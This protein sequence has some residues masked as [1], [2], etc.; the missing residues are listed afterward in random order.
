VFHGVQA[1]AQR[2]QSA[3]VPP[4]MA[5]IKWPLFSGA[6]LDFPASV[7]KQ[8]SVQASCGLQLDDDQLSD[9]FLEKCSL[10]LLA[11]RLAY[12]FTMKQ[13]WDFLDVV[14]K[15]HCRVL[16]ENLTVLSR[17]WSLKNGNGLQTRYS[18]LESVCDSGKMSGT[19]SPGDL[20]GSG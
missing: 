5:V 10:P 16:E 17:H 3:A 6:L 13:I 15:K 4:N 18:D 7:A 12:L 19:P 20:V 8:E 1:N 11:R 2:R 14:I 9:I